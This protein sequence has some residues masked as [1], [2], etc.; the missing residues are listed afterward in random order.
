[1]LS[2]PASLVCTAV[3]EAVELI[4]LFVSFFPYCIDIF[5]DVK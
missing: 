3:L 4:H 1:M 2:F 5:E